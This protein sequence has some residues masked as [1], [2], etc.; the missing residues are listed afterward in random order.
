MKN[1][2]LPNMRVLVDLHNDARAS[3]S[4]LRR[5]NSLIM[6]EKLMFYA[7]DWAKS[8]SSNGTMVHS[9]MR[10]ILNLGFKSAAENISW[11][12]SNEKE[13]MNSWL[14]SPGHRSNIM[15]MSYNKIGCAASYDLYGRLYWCV[16]FA[17]D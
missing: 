8:M 1:L 16:C 10:N 12:Q 2:Y 13:V 17:R 15:S 5:I 11:G 6:D 9:K 3:G 4:W 14:L 7:H